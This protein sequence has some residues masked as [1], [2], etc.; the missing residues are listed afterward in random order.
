MS[1][2]VLDLKKPKAVSVTVGSKAFTVVLSDGR[3]ILTPIDWFPRLLHGTAK[4]RSHYRLIGGGEGIHWPDLDED[5]SVEGI[6][7]G[8]PS[9]ESR[10][11]IER[12]LSTRKKR[13]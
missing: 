9:I 12:W 3:E 10:H 2:S 11:S 13:A 1:S 8:R 7:A 5:V 4:E 6:L